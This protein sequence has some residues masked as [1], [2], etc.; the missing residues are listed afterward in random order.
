MT[1]C[2]TFFPDPNIWSGG[3]LQDSRRFDQWG[4][5]GPGT[6]E[7]VRSDICKAPFKPRISIVSA[8]RLVF[9]CILVNLR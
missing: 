3:P 5:H 8:S 2:C 9:T 7:N 1:D 4:R 6:P